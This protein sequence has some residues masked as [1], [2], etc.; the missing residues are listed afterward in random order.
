MVWCQ[1]APGER[2]KESVDKEELAKRIIISL[3]TRVAE[4]E[5]EI[6]QAR[7][8]VAKENLVVVERCEAKVAGL[9][10]KLR[11]NHVRFP[12]DF[13]HECN[14]TSSLK[15]F[16]DVL[17]YDPDTF[18]RYPSEELP[19]LGCKGMV[20]GEGMEAVPVVA[21]VENEEVMP[22]GETPGTA[23]IHVPEGQGNPFV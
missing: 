12:A 15:Q 6:F 19:S 7:A 22:I 11:E 1:K 14:E 10:V 3:N 20:E 17:G 9:E 5:Q 8:Y 23:G 13:S 16:I 4:L 18:E 2:L 21:S